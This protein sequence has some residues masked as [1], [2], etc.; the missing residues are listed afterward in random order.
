MQESFATDISTW[1]HRLSVVVAVVDSIHSSSQYVCGIITELEILP[2][3][4]ASK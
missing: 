3:N 4:I 2:L 1:R